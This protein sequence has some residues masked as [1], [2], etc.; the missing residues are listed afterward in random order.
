MRSLLPAFPKRVAIGDLSTYL[1]GIPVA[2]M[3]LFAVYLANASVTENLRFA[4][5][6]DQLLNIISVA[7]DYAT[8]ESGFATRP[9]E[10]VVRTLAR[11]GMVPGLAIDEDTN[12]ITKLKNSWGGAIT[13]VTPF[14]SVLRLETFIPTRDCRRL[15]LFFVDDASG[16]GFEAMEA[17]EN[18]TGAW[19]RFYD[20]AQAHALNARAVEAACGQAPNA[21]LALIFR[22]R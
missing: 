19:R 13:V 5:A 4:R 20:R 17:R 10:D 7:R 2:A 3:I 21:L 18:G 8:R 1:V 22:A 15:A 16:L 14:Y 9:D 6:S 11:T 12:E